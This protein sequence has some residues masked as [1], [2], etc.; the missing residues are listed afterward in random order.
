MSMILDIQ[1][2]RPRI[3]SFLPDSVSLS[4]S[5]FGCLKS[6]KPLRLGSIQLTDSGQVELHA[7][8]MRNAQEWKAF[9]PAERILAIRDALEVV[10]NSHKSTRLFAAAIQRQSVDGDAVEYAF[11]QIASRFDQYLLRLHRQG[12]TQRGLMLFDRKTGE[13]KLQTLA[14]DFRRI[15]HSWGTLANLAEVPVFMDSKASRL[16][17]LAD[18]I[19]YAVYRNFQAGDDTFF[20]LIERRFDYANGVQHGL[21]VRRR[22]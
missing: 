9:A 11:E 3:G 10:N 20:K 16:I 13:R 4:A 14:T 19:A 2:I 8:A 18:L 22:S 15:G 1:T 17:Q 12:D 21:H 7:S 5:R 6:L